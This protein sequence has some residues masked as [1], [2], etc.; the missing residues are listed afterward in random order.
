MAQAD[1]VPSSSRQLITGESAN[2]STSL[3]AVKLPAV[4]VQPVDRRRFFGGSD[5]R[6]IS[7]TG[8]AFVFWTCRER[9]PDVE[10][11]DLSNRRWYA[12]SIGQEPRG[13]NIGAFETAGFLLGRLFGRFLSCFGSG[14]GMSPYGYARTTG[15]HRTS[16]SDRSHRGG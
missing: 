1:S 10:L 7:D 12:A 6:I 13:S 2:Q 16:W 3:R 4:S 15:C 8:A 9:R 5:A 14:A 11:E